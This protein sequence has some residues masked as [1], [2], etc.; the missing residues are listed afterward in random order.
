M[1]K[2]ATGVVSYVTIIGWIIAYVAGDREGA[3]FHLNQALVHDIFW[4]VLDIILG[5]IGLV[6]GWVPILGDIVVGLL[7]LLNIIPLVF[8]ILGILSASSGSDKPLPII[9]GIKLL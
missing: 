4:L 3:R 9:G 5:V 1:D 8:M 7:G 6:F 2:K